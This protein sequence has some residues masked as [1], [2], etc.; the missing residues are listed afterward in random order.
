[1]YNEVHKAIQNQGHMS[2]KQ[3]SKPIDINITKLVTKKESHSALTPFQHES[4]REEKAEES[5]T[6]HG[7]FVFKTKFSLN[8]F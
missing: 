7:I 1:M 8:C 3:E 5:N 4:Q 2:F 6:K